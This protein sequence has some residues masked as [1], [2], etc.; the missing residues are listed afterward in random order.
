MLYFA[1]PTQLDKESEGEVTTSD[2][3]QSVD[4]RDTEAGE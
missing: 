2:T 3:V 4:G 1:L